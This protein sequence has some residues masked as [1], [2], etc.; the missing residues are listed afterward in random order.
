[1]RSSFYTVKGSV[2][3]IDQPILAVLSREYDKMPLDMKTRQTLLHYVRCRLVKKTLPDIFPVVFRYKAL[4]FLSLYCDGGLYDC[5]SGRGAHL[6]A[7]IDDAVL[8]IKKPRSSTYRI[9]LCLLFHER[10]M[11]VDDFRL[12]IHALAVQ[13]KNKIACFKNSVPIHHGFNF[14]TMIEKLLLKAGLEKKDRYHPETIF[15]MYNALEF[16]EDDN[17]QLC[18]QYRG[19]PLILPSE[20]NT[21]FI[22]HTIETGIQFLTRALFSES[23]MIYSIN[24]ITKEKTI[25][26]TLSSVTRMLASLWQYV[27]ALR[28]KKTLTPDVVSGVKKRIQEIVSAYFVSEKNDGYCAV[29]E[30]TSISINSFLLLAIT[31]IRDTACFKTEAALLTA[32]LQSK[33]NQCQYW[34]EA[35]QGLLSLS[36]SNFAI[37]EDTFFHY[38]H[39]FHQFPEKKFISLWFIKTYAY[40]FQVTKRNDYVDFIFEINDALLPY[41]IPPGFVE[42]DAT[43]HFSKE[44]DLR[45][46]ACFL[47]SIALAYQIADVVRDSGRKR[48]YQGAIMQGLRALAQLQ[49][50]SQN[51]GDVNAAGGFKTSLFDSAL[52]IDNTQHAVAALVQSIQCGCML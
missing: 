2:L 47:E 46:T 9:S 28:F 29:N 23:A 6:L 22:N 32:W 30:N 5:V 34:W 42:A 21:H 16:T 33:L 15:F 20:I 50:G 8:H 7:A 48:K 27:E 38:R 44:G 45:T 43:G 35:G 52:R 25:K 40:A 14:P 37:I 1:M 41:Q 4:C 10:K 51:R 13:N 24:S 31:S 19:N 49:C 26:H 36:V 12:G 3:E 18:D 39:L 17:H 11:T